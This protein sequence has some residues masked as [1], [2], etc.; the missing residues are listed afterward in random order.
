[1]KLARLLP[2]LLVALAFVALAIGCKN[3]PPAQIVT[4]D[5][6]PVI[7]A[8]RTSQ[9]TVLGEVATVRDQLA[10]AVEASAG[11][12][13]EPAV[14]AAA[15]QV[16][17]SLAAVEAAVAAAPAADLE[18]IFA[19]F[20]AAIETLRAVIA[21][22]DAE[23]ERLRDADARFWNRVLVGLGIACTLGAVASLFHASIPVVGVFLGP[24]IA[25]VLG[26]CAAT[27]FALAWLAAWTR[28]NPVKTGIIV[29]A[30]LA[31]AAGLAWGNRVQH[32]AA[33]PSPLPV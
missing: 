27:C 31:T 5:A 2:A 4:P 28:D 17:T 3:T 10:A 25:A 13:S 15:A 11:L 22:R 12:P 6:A 29:A 8:A 32:R 24:R 9:A 14:R 7:D 21:D 30:T 26:A 18:K 1:M 16:E 33:L 19:Q 20:E 23:I